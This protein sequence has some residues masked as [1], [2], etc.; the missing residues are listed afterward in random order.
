MRSTHK[1]KFFTVEITIPGQVEK[2]CLFINTFACGNE[3]P[4]IDL[5]NF[6]LN[7]STGEWCDQSYSVR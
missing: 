6:N 5:P 7:K 4:E 2:T 3:T 1:L